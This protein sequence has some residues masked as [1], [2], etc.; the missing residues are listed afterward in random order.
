MA[1]T[2]DGIIYPIASDPI[3]PLNAHIQA[4]AE[5]VQDA[6]NTKVPLAPV[7]YTPTFTG[8]T[9]GDGLVV[10]KYTKI[11]NIIID[12][13]TIGFGSTTAITGAVTVGG[14][15]PAITSGAYLPCGNAILNA[16][17][18][19][20]VGTVTQATTTAVNILAQNSSSTYLSVS[21]LS[22]SV[23]ATWVVSNAIFIKTFRLAA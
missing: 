18:G 8:L 6:I 3:A 7:S 14:M 12:E 20:Y 19:S 11:G 10:A 16:G 23:P 9:V 17:G 1:T 5:S 15:Q 2:A 13:I 21:N 22:S 4:L